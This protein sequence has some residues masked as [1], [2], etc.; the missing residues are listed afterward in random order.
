M[1]FSGKRIK[2][3]RQRQT[4]EQFFL[5]SVFLQYDFHVLSCS[6]KLLVIILFL[7][8]ENKSKKRKEKLAMPNSY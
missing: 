3:I 2:M 4:T 1:L 6:E 7:N 8:N 5:L